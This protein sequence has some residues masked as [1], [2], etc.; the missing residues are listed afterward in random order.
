MPFPMRKKEDLDFTTGQ[1]AKIT[2]TSINTIIRLCD[3]GTLEHYRVPGSNFRRITRMALY[4]L[5]KDNGI[6]TDRLDDTKKKR[7][8]LLGKRDTAEALQSGETGLEVTHAES[9]FDAGMQFAELT[10]RTP[11]ITALIIDQDGRSNLQSIVATAKEK[12]PLGELKFV[13]LGGKKP[14]GFNLHFPE[15]N[16][17]PD[18]IGK[19]QRLVGIEL[20]DATETAET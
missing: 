16:L 19:I 10:K 9:S 15:R 3:D 5:M 1:A 20:E 8:L 17:G 13:S 11:P 7:V 6:P 4:K 14:R 18:Q 2:L 12:D